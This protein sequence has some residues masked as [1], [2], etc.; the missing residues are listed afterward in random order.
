MSTAAKS[1]VKLSPFPC[2]FPVGAE[3]VGGAVDAEMVRSAMEE[4]RAALL[5]EEKEARR[6][7]CCCICAEAPVDAVLLPCR[8]QQLCMT[9]AQAVQLCPI[10]RAVID[11]RLQVY[12]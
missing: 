3:R 4:I 9:C 8:H 6:R 1:E 5:E 7:R 12:L 2:L 10:C 11:S